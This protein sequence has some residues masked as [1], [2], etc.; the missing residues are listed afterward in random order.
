MNEINGFKHSFYNAE[1][2]SES[3]P[4]REI[5]IDQYLDIDNNLS[6]RAKEVGKQQLF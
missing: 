4:S 1:S 3:K 2:H 5:T 6:S